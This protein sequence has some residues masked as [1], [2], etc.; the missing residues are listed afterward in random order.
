MCA[1][2]EARC[3]TPVHVMRE[4]FGF[5]DTEAILLV[6]ASYAFNSI[7]RQAALHD[8]Q[9]ICPAISATHTGF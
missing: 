1:G 9:F 6:D 2:H 5:E 7:N 3:E 4:I 8:I